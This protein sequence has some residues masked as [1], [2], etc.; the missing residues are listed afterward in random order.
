MGAYLVAGMTEQPA[1]LAYIGLGSNL[2]HA[3]QSGVELLSTALDDLA[4]HPN[5]ALT[6]VSHFYST[7]ALVA[8]PSDDVPD[9]CNAVAQIQTTLSGEHLLGVLQGLELAHGRTRS[10][11]QRWQARTLDLDVLL[12][13]DDI[14]ASPHLTVP[15]LE[16]HHRGFV[17]YPLQDI[18]NAMSRTITI[19]HLGNVDDVMARFLLKN[20]SSD[21]PQM[22]ERLRATY[23]IKKHLTF[24]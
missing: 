16:L 8:T 11:N 1:V 3:G 10:P 22:C 6:C 9:Y 24:K 13:G 19:P 7:S 15:H 2:P 18:Q 4:F 23:T 5:I 20:Q 12:Y 17:L 21:N 14:I